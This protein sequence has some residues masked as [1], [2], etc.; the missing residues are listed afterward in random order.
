MRFKLLGFPVLAL[1]ILSVAIPAFSQ[2]APQYERK[3]GLP[4]EVGAG[5]VSYDVDWGHGRMYG[6][7]A[8]VDYYPRF[9]PSFLH[10][11]GIE[12]EARDISLDEHVTQENMRQDTGEGGPIYAW[13][14]FRNF[15]PYAK[16]LI[17]DGSVDFWTGPT[18]NYRHDTRI[19]RAP[20]GGLEVHVFR[21]WW[22]RADYEYQTWP[23]LFTKTLDPQGFTVGFAYDFAHSGSRKRD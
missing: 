4:I 22:M 18:S 17:G 6:G 1:S 7:A 14:H 5:G 10:G 8:W 19:I 20:G 21:A 2:V 9:M 23:N 13:L 11:L 16:Y 15:H 12:G 3:G